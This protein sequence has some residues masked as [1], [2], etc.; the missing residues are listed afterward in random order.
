MVLHVL[1]D[2]REILTKIYA[3]LSQIK[4]TSCDAMSGR[5]IRF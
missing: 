3:P 5:A 4:D 2:A 1:V